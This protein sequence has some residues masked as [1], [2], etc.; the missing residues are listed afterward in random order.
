MAVNNWS[1][2]YRTGDEIVD[3]HHRELFELVE[4]L[5]MDISFGR[6][7]AALAPTL[8]KVSTLATLHFA[9]E[10]KLM[11]DHQYPEIE[12]H[13]IQHQQ[14]TARIG[15]AMDQYLS[16][17]LLLPTTLALELHK[18]IVE[19]ICVHDRRMIQWV[20]RNAPE[21]LAVSVQYVALS[22]GV[23]TLEQV[24]TTA[25]ARAKVTSDERVNRVSSSCERA[26]ESVRP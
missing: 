1:D 5:E 13:S 14:A 12:E 17:V 25:E 21:A 23:R 3:G 8:R 26:R 22:S 7:R 2:D 19:H 4:R 16:G 15:S 20:R 10:E 6:G 11:V 18:W 24:R 9:M